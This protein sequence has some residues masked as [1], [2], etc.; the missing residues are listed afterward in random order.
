[1]ISLNSTSLN[2]LSDRVKHPKYDRIRVKQGIVHIGVGGFHRSHQA[3][4]INKILTGGENN[5]WGICGIGLR[6]ADQ[7]IYETLSNQDGLYNLIT[8]HPNGNIETE[9]IGS[10]VNFIWAYNDPEEALKK[11]SEPETKIVSLTITE[12]GYNFDTSTGD[13]NLSH[14]D[15]KHDLDKKNTPKT[16]FGFLTEAARRRMNAGYTS[17]T[18]MS[19]DNIQHNGDVAKKMFLSF[20]KHQDLKVYHWMLSNTA[21]PNSMVDRI[22][23]VT[24]DE[25]INYLQD[26]YSIIDKWPVTCEP[27]VQWVLEDNFSSNRPPL[28]NVNVQLV[29]DVNPY[30]KMKIRLLNAGHSVLGIPGSLHGHPTINSCMEDTIFRSFMRKFMDLEATPTLDPVPGIDLSQYKDSLE[31]RFGNRNLKDTVERICSESSSKLPK[32]LFETITENLSKERSIVMGSFIVACWFYYYHQGKNEQGKGLIIIDEL[33][34]QLRK[35]SESSE[36][37]ISNFSLFGELSVNKRFLK[38]YSNWAEKLMRGSK[39]RQL[40]EDIISE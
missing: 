31:D 38:S 8:R 18:V 13:F 30:E 15:I 9:I 22:T 17:F 6:E 25:D 26:E 7:K 23:P 35:N 12:G 10:I 39:V 21:F 34:E 20:S 2:S 40:M 24:T 4:Y 28:E 33:S 14:P 27:F 11:L 1:M 5:E 32:F 29:E 16:V 36:S 37:F 19:C 3:Y